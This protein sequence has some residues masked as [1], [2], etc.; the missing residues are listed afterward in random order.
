MK[1]ATQLRAGTETGSL[2]NSVISGLA[3][4]KPTAGMGATVLMWTDRRAATIVEVSASG[5]RVGVRED[6][7]IPLFEG[8]TDAQSYRYE[9]GDGPVDYY[10]LRRNGA[11]VLEGDSMKG[12]RLAIGQRAS[13]YDFSF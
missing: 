4:P 9:P 8:M 11:F 12:R 5:K 7:S 1:T 13:Y 10:T 2:F 6:K 3:M